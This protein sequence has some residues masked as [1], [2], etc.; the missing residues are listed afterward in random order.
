MPGSHHSNM[1]LG[2][3]YANGTCDHVAQCHPILGGRFRMV[4]RPFNSGVQGFR[5]PVA[6]LSLP[7]Y[8]DIQ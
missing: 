8:F 4:D 2:Y 3:V 1:T 6:M 7:V 5:P